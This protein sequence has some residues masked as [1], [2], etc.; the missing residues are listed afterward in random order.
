MCYV[1][2]TKYYSG[3]QIKKS[4]MGGKCSACWEKRGAYRVMV[5]K[6]EGK[7]SRKT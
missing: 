1:Q 2:L 5:V 7:G 4:E 3:D 6:P